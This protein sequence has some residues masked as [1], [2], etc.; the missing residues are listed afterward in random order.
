MTDLTSIR[1]HRTDRYTDRALEAFAAGFSSQAQKKA[2]MSDLNRAFECALDTLFDLAAASHGAEALDA[3][4]FD[5]HHWRPKHAEFAAKFDAGLTETVNRLAELRETFKAAVVVPPVKNE[6]ATKAKV[7]ETRVLGAINMDKIKADYAHAL[8][9]GYKL[10][11]LPVTLR[12]VYCQN[13]HGTQY[14]RPI[15][16]LN[17]QVTRFNVIA[18][19]YQKLVDDGVIVEDNT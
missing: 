5:L 19:A 17:G 1:K 11:D 2:A 16:Y 13:L 10:G 12:I 3:L 9:L 6:E 4:P 15:W 14:T 8:D 7:L 18:A